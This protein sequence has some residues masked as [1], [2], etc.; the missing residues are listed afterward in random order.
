MDKILKIRHL[1]P[2]ADVHVFTSVDE[3]TDQREFNTYKSAG[4]HVHTD[5]DKTW[6]SHAVLDAW[7]HI[8]RADFVILSRSSFG[9]VPAM[10]NTNCVIYQEYWNAP[11]DGW[12]WA[13]N[14][15]KG[16]SNL[17]DMAAFNRCV[18]RIARPSWGIMR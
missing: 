15:D 7:A 16:S 2:N 18:G 6:A 11:M 1:M 3:S 9:H 8:A 4:C 5:E 12:I 14:S 13:E 10:L 17:F